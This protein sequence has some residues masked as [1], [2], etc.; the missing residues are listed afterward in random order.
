MSATTNNT[1]NKMTR[2]E[3]VATFGEETG[4]MMF[5][6]MNESSGSGGAPFTF[7]KKISDHDSETGAKWGDHVI[8]AKF[9]KN[10]AGEKVLVDKGTN[11]GDSFDI[12]V[13]NVG[14]QYSRWN[15]AAER[16]ETS[17]AFTDIVSG[18]KGAVNSHTGEPLPKSKDD[19]KAADWKMKKVMGVLVRKDAKSPWEPAIYEISGK[20]YYTFGV[21]TDN[22]PSKGLMD[23]VYTLK[24]EK[25]KKGSTTYTIIDVKKATFTPRPADFFQDET[26]RTL[27]GDITTKMTEWRASQQYGEASDTSIKA[28]ST[29]GVEGD[30]DIKW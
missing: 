19:K 22:K 29:A 17:N 30:D 10:D 14:Y 8:N 20:T 3:L 26:V 25:E 5:D 23:G 13:V 2:E 27:A 6:Q 15:D 24:F 9:E 28:P 4:N 1:M 7:L 21:L 18:I 16:T 11:L 12:F